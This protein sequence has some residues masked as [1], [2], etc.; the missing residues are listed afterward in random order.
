MICHFGVPMPKG[1]GFSGCYPPTKRLAINLARQVAK[2][3]SSL[4]DRILSLT[5][6]PGKIMGALGFEP[7]TKGL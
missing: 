7:R 1:G 3:G 4:D 2:Q 5:M 6:R